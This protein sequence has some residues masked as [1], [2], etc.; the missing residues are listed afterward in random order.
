[1]KILDLG[2]GKGRNI[3]YLHKLGFKNLTGIDLF[4]F[5]EIDT[6]KIKFIQTDLKYGIPVNEKYSLILCNYIL[7]FI[8]DRKKIINEITAISEKKAFCI[9]ELNP[10]KLKNGTPYDF[11]EIVNLFGK[12]W[13]IVNIRNNRVIVVRR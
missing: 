8:P 4:K 5:K 1:M 7:M 12:N 11:N 13:D 9:I 3:Y 10:K 6:K 2:I